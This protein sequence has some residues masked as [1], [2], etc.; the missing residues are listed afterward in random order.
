MLNST[1]TVRGVQGSYDL[2]PLS[3]MHSWNRIKSFKESGNKWR[4]SFLS[5]K[6]SSIFHSHTKFTYTSST[7]RLPPTLLIQPLTSFCSSNLTP[8]APSLHLHFPPLSPHSL[9]FLSRPLPSSFDFLCPLVLHS[10]LLFI[11]SSI[12]VLSGGLWQ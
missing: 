9:L 7:F 1:K 10:L 12:L 2:L 3:W 8:F 11:L 6:Y 5:F 4:I